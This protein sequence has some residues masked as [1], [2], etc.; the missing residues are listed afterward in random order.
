M[1]DKEKVIPALI[2][3]A[4][5]STTA[6]ARQTTFNGSVTIGSDY[7]SN[8]FQTDNNRT[9]EWLNTLETK[10]A[11]ESK[12]SDNLVSLSYNPTFTY[13][14][15]RET[16]SKRH[17]LDMKVQRDIS[18]RWQMTLDNA[19]S[20]RDSPN[21]E[22]NAAL[23]LARQFQ[24]A[25]DF[26]Q[27]EVV[28]ILFPEI[29]WEPQQLTYVLSDISTRYQQATAQDQ[30]TVSNLLNTNDGQGRQRYFTNDLSLT[31]IYKFAEDSQ[32][33]MGYT[34]KM[35]DNRTGIQADK[36]GHNPTIDLTWRLNKSWLFEGGYNYSY[37]HFDTTDDS[38]TN[39]PHLRASYNFAANNK[40][41][42]GFDYEDITYDGNTASSTNQTFSL[43]WD[44][45]LDQLTTIDSGLDLSYNNRERAGDERELAVSLGL[46]R[47]IDRG[48]I[49]VSGDS[50]WTASNG[51]G[52]WN[53]L[54]QAWG[55]TTTANYQ[56]RQD[57]TSTADVSYE[58][59]YAWDNQG[60]TTYNDLKAG[61]GLSWNFYRWF[62]LDVNYDYKLLDSDST[63]LDDYNEHLITIKLS[64]ANLWQL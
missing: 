30:N 23:S 60:K 9:D 40:L 35:L 12:G 33:V 61:A 55:L 14:N 2:L 26:T 48:S 43:S 62:S 28:R 4:L 16:T 10:M 45:G 13:N 3:C 31:S 51:T 56:F 54:R 11:L 1:A 7:D 19:Y 47:R 22:S 21:F 37:K 41:T 38:T 58:R 15:R 52:S 5:I 46:T 29:V 59:R 42:A 17:D 57:L 53:D 64:A 34:L 20:Y 36:T 6:A 49:S 50:S 25:D 27:T 39:N 8:V 44:K 32:L 24:R 18:E 63:Y